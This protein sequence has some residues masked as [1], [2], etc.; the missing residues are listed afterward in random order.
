MEII[1]KSLIRK[2]FEKSMLTYNENANIQKEIGTELMEA[3]LTHYPNDTFAQ[4]LELGA[5]TGLYTQKII[6][7]LNFKKLN[8]NDLS[9]N[10]LKGLKKLIPAKKAIQFNFIKGDFEDTSKLL[11][12]NNLITANAAIQWLENPAI[13]FASLPK[14]LV[15]KG[16]I[17]FSTFAPGNLQEIKELTG[18]HL[19]YHSTTT[20][21]RFIKPYFNIKYIKQ[22]Q[23]Q[24]KFKSPRAIL[25]HLKHTGVTG[26][27]K[28]H[29]TKNALLAFEDKYRARFSIDI[30]TE[31]E[32]ST[33]VTLTYTPIIIIAELK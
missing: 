12:N 7:K 14:L 30:G 25:R 31:L 22:K 9:D 24:L 16:I 27:K 20:L 19:N 28:M 10:Y 6:A 3:L 11:T 17:A 26:I 4:V 23:Y 29:W 15:P 18:F 21:E 13:F 8:C 2:R 33:Q 32:P 5:G 1:D